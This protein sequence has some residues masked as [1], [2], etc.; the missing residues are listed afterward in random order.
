MHVPEIVNTVLLLGLLGL[1]AFLVVR[2][3]RNNQRSR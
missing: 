3:L 2:R 1:L